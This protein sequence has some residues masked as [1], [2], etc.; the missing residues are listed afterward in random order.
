MNYNKEE[1]QQEKLHNPIKNI[2]VNIIKIYIVDDAK[3][4]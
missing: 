4:N 3:F 2:N 1:H